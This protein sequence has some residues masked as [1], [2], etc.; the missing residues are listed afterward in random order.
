MTEDEDPNT[1][2]RESPYRAAEIKELCTSRRAPAFVRCPVC[3]RQFCRQYTCAPKCCPDCYI[4]L[5]RLQLRC[6][7][8]SAAAIVS[9]GCVVLSLVYEVEL[10]KFFGM[11]LLF[12]PTVVMF[13]SPL[14][15]VLYKKY[16][17]TADSPIYSSRGPAVGRSPELGKMRGPAVGRSPE[18]VG[19][20]RGRARKC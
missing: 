8:W 12:I 15:Y 4:K 5:R 16:I 10:L 11:L 7:F 18:L 2:L 20:M 3:G 9:I 19:K 6:G 14:A 17:R 13:F 1:S